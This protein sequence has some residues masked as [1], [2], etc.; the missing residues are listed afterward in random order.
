[1]NERD[2]MVLGELY[3]PSDAELEEDRLR[4]RAILARYNTTP[5][6]QLR[7]ELLR[8]LFQSAGKKFL[9]EPPFHCDFGYNISIGDDVFAN[10]GCVFLDGSTIAIGNRVLFGPHVQ[11]YTEGHPLE[12]ELREADFEKCAPI[13]IGDTVWIGGNTVVCPGVTIGEHTVIGA[14]SVVTKHIPPG[15]LAVGNPCRVIRDLTQAEMRKVLRA[16]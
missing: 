1:M 15:V 6:L 5:D 14:G 2:K 7:E 12:W 16:V 8:S 10:V 11:L 13:A 4:A 9:F 3:D